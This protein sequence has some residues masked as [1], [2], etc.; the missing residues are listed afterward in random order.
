MARFPRWRR[1][2]AVPVMPRTSESDSDSKSVSRSS[3]VRVT[4]TA[5]IAS[6]CQWHG[7]SDHPNVASM[8]MIMIMMMVTATPACRQPECSEPGSGQARGPGPAAAVFPGS[9]RAVQVQAA[10]WAGTPAT[11]RRESPSDSVVVHLEGCVMVYTTFRKVELVYTIAGSND[12][13]HMVY[14]IWYIS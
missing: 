14:T 9:N 2:P 1:A 6:H 7:D 3:P 8:I 11:R 12:M 13:Y 10:A 4:V 5:I